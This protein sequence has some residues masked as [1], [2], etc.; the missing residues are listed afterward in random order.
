ML[1]KPRLKR[2]V[3]QIPR[4]R[5]LKVAGVGNGHNTATHNVRMPIVLQQ[6][7]GKFR[8]G[9]FEFPVLSQQ[10][11][12]PAGSGGDN[13][14]GL[15]GLETLENQLC[16]LDHVHH[17]LYCCGP[18]DFDLKAC[19]PPGTEEY[20]LTHAPSGHLILPTDKYAAFD[21]RQAQGD[22]NLE[23]IHLLTRSE[24]ESSTRSAM[25]KLRESSDSEPEEQR[26][27]RHAHF[28]D[29]NGEF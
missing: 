8:T 21:R 23:P 1:R 3:T 5:S 19:L 17:K 12:A 10:P 13:V 14:P 27:R 26:R 22:M 25:P 11:D 2:P 18:G 16:I 7:S 24:S 6:T 28:A 20:Q 15:L 29:D 4:E 9:D